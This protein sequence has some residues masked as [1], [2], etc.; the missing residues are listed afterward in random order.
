[1]LTYCHFP[2]TLST[3]STSLDTF[4]HTAELFAIHCTRFADLGAD[5]ANTRMKRWSAELKIGR[6]L[7]NLGTTHHE[8]EV[9]CFNMLTASLKAVVHSGLKADLMAM[10]TSRYTGLH[11]GFNVGGVMHRV[12]LKINKSI[13]KEGVYNQ[14]TSFGEILGCVVTLWIS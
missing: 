10:A 6:C 8:T 4:I 9:F 2:A 11:G 3:G 1:M 12:L 14:E 7:A 5:F 13:G